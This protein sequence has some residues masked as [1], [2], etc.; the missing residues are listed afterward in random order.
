MSR[1]AIRVGLV[2]VVALVLSACASTKGAFRATFNGVTAVD[3]TAGTADLSVSVLDAKGKV[4]LT[5]TLTQASATVTSATSS[6]VPVPTSYGATAL[7][8]GNVTGSTGDIT[9]ILTLDA[10]GSMLSSDPSR[11]RADAAKGFVARMASTDRVAVA[12]FDTSTTPTAGYLAIDLHQGLTSDK[13]LLD[14]AIDAATF[15]GGATN[16]WDAGVDSATLLAGETGSNKIAVLLTDG[17][18]NNNTSTPSDVVTAAQSAGVKV[19]TVGLG[20]FVDE[21]GLI[22]VSSQTGG[23]FA[24]VQDAADL[25][26]LFDGVFNATKAAGCIRLAFAPSPPSGTTLQGRVTFKIDGEP[27]TA[28]YTVAFP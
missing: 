25:S 4:I 2:V 11:L 9:G 14:T 26:G 16:L 15:E 23:T 5:G 1:W 21:Q 3:G 8:C 10:T 24:A 18:D 28:N 19:F 6:G 13:A 17:Q 27:V 12:S 22:T 7:V 20:S